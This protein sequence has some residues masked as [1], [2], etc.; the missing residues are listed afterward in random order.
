MQ[1]YIKKENLKINEQFVDKTKESPKKYGF[2]FFLYYSKSSIKAFK[3]S[4]PKTFI[5]FFKFI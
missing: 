1:G 5:P 4:I 3:F 2:L